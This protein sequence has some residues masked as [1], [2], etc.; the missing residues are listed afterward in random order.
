MHSISHHKLA[1]VVVNQ[2]IHFP[3]PPLNR[4]SIVREEARFVAVAGLPSIAA[5]KLPA[6]F[7]LRKVTDCKPPKLNEAHVRITRPPELTPLQTVFRRTL[8][9]HEFVHLRRDIELAPE[10]V[11]ILVDRVLRQTQR[12]ESRI[13]ERAATVV[14][15]SLSRMADHT[16]VRSANAE[17]ATNAV[18]AMRQGVNPSPQST[19]YPG[20]PSIEALTDQVVQQIDRRMTAWRE[21]MGRI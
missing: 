3:T 14:R 21:R 19:S 1:T 5:G 12:V 10:R 16:S 11:R 9:T 6:R 18:P 8:F 17:P 13:M 20:A 7:T 2:D 15:Q 4:E